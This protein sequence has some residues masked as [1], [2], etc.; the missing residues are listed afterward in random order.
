MNNKIE[1]LDS[2]NLYFPNPLF[3]PAN[4]PIAIGGDLKPERLVLAYKSGIFPWYCDY[5]PILWWSPD[6]R[7]V[8]FIDELHISKSLDKK[9]R[10]NIFDLTID[11]DFEKVII[12]CAKVKRKFQ[13]GTW[14]TDEMIEAY[15][16][17]HKMGYAHSIETRLNNELVGGFYGVNIGCIFFGESMFHFVDDASKYA[18]AKFILKLKE[19]TNIDII[20]CQVYTDYLSSFGAKLISRAEY[21]NLLKERI[22]KDNNINDWF[23]ILN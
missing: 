17:L 23:K 2:K 22:D 15:I 1:L 20:D 10:K 11:N 13:N 18:F 21:I 12:N 7:F 9:L 8:L 16:K 5:S 6:P 3:G 14:I 19:K 4:K